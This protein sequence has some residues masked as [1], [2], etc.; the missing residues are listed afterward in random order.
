MTKVWAWTK[1]LLER[2]V[3]IQRPCLSDF[4]SVC[5]ITRMLY[6]LLVLLPFVLSERVFIESDVNLME[7]SGW[8]KHEAD[9]NQEITITVAIKQ[10]N[11]EELEVQYQI[12]RDFE[13]MLSWFLM[14]YSYLGYILDIK[15]SCKFGVWRLDEFQQ[16]EPGMLYHNGVYRRVNSLLANSAIA[17]QCK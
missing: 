8:V 6:L 9:Q 2:V 4:T 10:S 16:I 7:H 17:K 11:L 13:M 12:L 14:I 1:S 15:W 5:W 3:T